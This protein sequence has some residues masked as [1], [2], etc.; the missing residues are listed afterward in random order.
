MSGLNL[1]PPPIFRLH[2]GS[3]GTTRVPKKVVGKLIQSAEVHSF[4]LCESN[5]WFRGE[6]DPGWV[7]SVA[8]HDT[9]KVARLAESLRASFNQEG[10]GVEGFGRYLRCKADHGPELVAAELWGLCH[11]FHPA[12]YRTVFSANETDSWPAQFAIV[13]AYATTGETWPAE[14]NQQA[15]RDLLARIEERG[16]W[17]KRV[18]G[19]SPDGLHVEPGWAIEVSLEEAQILGRD[20]RQDAIY[21]VEADLLHVASCFETRIATVGAFRLRLNTQKGTTIL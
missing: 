17:R 1:N 10:V 13:T 9:N 11:G 3:V 12:Y 18:T 2:L 5:G 14:R 16:Y 19:A 8:D 20:F 6:A 7:I 4:S 21:F 15:D